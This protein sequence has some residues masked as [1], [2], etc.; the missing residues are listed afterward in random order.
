MWRF[1]NTRTWRWQENERHCKCN[2][3]TETNTCLT[4]LLLSSRLRP[5]RLESCFLFV[6]CSEDIKNLHES[7][8]N[9]QDRTWSGRCWAGAD[10]ACS[11]KP[12]NSYLCIHLLTCTWHS[13]SLPSSPHCI[14][15]TLSAL[16]DSITLSVA[17]VFCFAVLCKGTIALKRTFAFDILSSSAW[18]RRWKSVSTCDNSMEVNG[19]SHTWCTDVPNFMPRFSTDLKVSFHSFMDSPD[20]LILVPSLNYC[21]EHCI[22]VIYVVQVIYMRLNQIYD[23][24][25]HSIWI[26]SPNTLTPTSHSLY[27]PVSACLHLLPKLC[28]TFI[29]P[30]EACIEHTFS[31]TAPLRLST[32]QVNLLINNLRVC[33][34]FN[35]DGWWESYLLPSFSLTISILS[36]QVNMH[37]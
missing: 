14:A 11:S 24:K 27:T 3:R 12:A 25:T 20:K 19:V 10:I 1:W 22:L 21:R 30:P 28:N 34:P 26:S 31:Q 32:H 7:S 16:I 29:K 4:Y 37:C 8:H 36:D 5:L 17:E 18:P 15:S 6:L 35:G 23:F 13:K 33:G 2:D 9:R